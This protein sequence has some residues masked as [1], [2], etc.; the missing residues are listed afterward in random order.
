[1]ISNA[2]HGDLRLG[3]DQVF[4]AFARYLYAS[5][6]DP[7][8][9]PDRKSERVGSGSK[10]SCDGA[11][12]LGAP[13]DPKPEIRHR[14]ALRLRHNGVY[15]NRALRSDVFFVSLGLTFTISDLKSLRSRSKSDISSHD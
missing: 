6:S 8:L 11:D 1:M 15:R 4:P 7:E 2:F 5:L 10:V 13:A 12:G 9:P 14:S 3:A